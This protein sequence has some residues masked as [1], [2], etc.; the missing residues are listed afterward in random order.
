MLS[1][2]VKFCGGCNPRFDRGAFYRALVKELEG[3]ATFTP[4]KPGGQ[5]DVLVILHGCESCADRYEEVKAA[6]RIFVTHRVSLQE[7]AEAVRALR[8]NSQ[9]H[10]K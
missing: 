1:C 2:T 10:Y 3:I 6:H 9:H 5:Y 8:E 7:A 4:A